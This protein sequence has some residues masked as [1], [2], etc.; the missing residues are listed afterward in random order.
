M[1]V[2]EI[3]ESERYLVFEFFAYELLENIEEFL[4]ACAACVISHPSGEKLANWRGVA[5]F[6]LCM[7][8]CRSS[9]IVRYPIDSY[10]A[11]GPRHRILRRQSEPPTDHYCS[12]VCQFV[13]VGNCNQNKAF[14]LNPVLESEM[15]AIIIN[16][17]LIIYLFKSIYNSDKFDKKVDKYDIFP[18]S[19]GS[20][21]DSSQELFKYH[22]Q[23]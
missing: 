15:Q 21:I 14:H 23:F 9:S 1:C 6:D 18:L 8:V 10:G 12:L 3:R 5:A 7:C 17:K 19:I 13:V 16:L 11:E 20:W 4:L 22:L 2:C